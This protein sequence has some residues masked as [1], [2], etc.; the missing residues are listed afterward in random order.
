VL[1]V[2]PADVLI[3][4][5]ADILYPWLLLHQPPLPP[6]RRRNDRPAFV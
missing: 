6:A 5:D 3:L 4:D 2:L 1:H